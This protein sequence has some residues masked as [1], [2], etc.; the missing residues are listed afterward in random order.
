MIGRVD[1]IRKNGSVVAAEVPR[2]KSAE[3]TIPGSKEKAQVV[4]TIDRGT[5]IVTKPGIEIDS[6]QWMIVICH[7]NANC[8]HSTFMVSICVTTCL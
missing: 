3:T 8:S 7:A 1:T 5:V 4:D 2:E 6:V